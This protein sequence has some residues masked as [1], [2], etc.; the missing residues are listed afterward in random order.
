MHKTLEILLEAK[1][2][3][4]TRSSIDV[5]IAKIHLGDNMSCF[6]TMSL[7]IST[8]TG[9]NVILA[10]NNCRDDISAPMSAWLEADAIMVRLPFGKSEFEIRTLGPEPDGVLKVSIAT[11]DIEDISEPIPAP[12]N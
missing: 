9:C 1:V 12:A 10:E 8:K 3:H 11:E 4:F 5:D 6:H 2:L 7:V